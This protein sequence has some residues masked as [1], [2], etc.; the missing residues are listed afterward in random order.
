[1]RQDNINE[2]CSQSAPDVHIS[3]EITHNNGND[4]VLYDR[5]QRDH[6]PHRSNY[7]LFVF[8]TRVYLTKV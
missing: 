4:L 2:W 5:G 1:M 7:S 8:R 6:S 3:I